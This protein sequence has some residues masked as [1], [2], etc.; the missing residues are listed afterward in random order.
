MA[1][2]KMK[3]LCS[4]HIQKMEKW[5]LCREVV[6]RADVPG[7]CHWDRSRTDN[8][9][10]GREAKESLTFCSRSRVSKNKQERSLGFLLDGSALGKVMNRLRT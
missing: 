6:E 7:G 9:Q 1:S 2:A 4:E 3:F 10:A 8:Q 5:A